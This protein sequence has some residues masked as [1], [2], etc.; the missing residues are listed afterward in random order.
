M[1]DWNLRSKK[2]LLR[3]DFNVPIDANG[4]ITDDTRIEKALPTVRAL[5]DQ[6]ARVILMSHLGRP[7]KSLLPDGSIDKVRFSLAPVAVRLAEL[8]GHEVLFASDCGG[9]DSLAKINQ[10]SDGQL[11]LMENTRFYKQEE[12]GDSEWAA[13][14]AKLGEFYLNDAFG[15]AH[16]EHA[17]TATIARYFDKDHKGFGYLMQAELESASRVMDHPERPLTAILGGAKV[18]DKIELISNLLDRCDQILIGGGMAYTFFA[19]QGYA[20]GQSLCE[21]D[22][23]P[24]ALELLEKAKSKKVKMVLPLDSVAADA[25]RAEARTQIT[26]DVSIPDGYMGLDIGPKSVKVFREFILNS[27]TIIWNGPM[28]VFEMEPFSH[29]TAEVAKAVAE[30]TYK[31]CFTL[32]GGGDSVAAVNRFGLQDDVSFVSTGGGAMLELLEGKILPGVAAIR[33]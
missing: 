2:V 6:G 31:G 5:I 19:A 24:L 15:A 28:G 32:V 10:L 11:L 7:L 26:Q 23:L 30:A 29:G 13:S 17:T 20:I 27:R 16:R 9:D 21:Q 12:K 14:L 33:D 8:T 22:K 3:V 25:F 4:K 1:K 18:S